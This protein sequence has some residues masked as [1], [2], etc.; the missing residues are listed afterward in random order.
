M[1]SKTMKW[2]GKKSSL[3]GTLVS[4]ALA[5]PSFGATYYV[6]TTG[7]NANTGQPSSPWRDIGY[8]AARVAPGDTVRV[9]AGTYEQRISISIGGNS[10]NWVNFLA[11]GRVVCR[12]FD[13]IGVNFVRIIGF[14]ITHTSLAYQRAIEIAHV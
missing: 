4:L 8:A 12:G 11:E 9:Q 10:G 6:A 2:Y 14:E 13:L 5:L 3:L 1:F 7:N